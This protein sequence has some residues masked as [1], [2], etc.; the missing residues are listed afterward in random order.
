MKR[1]FATITAGAVV[2]LLALVPVTAIPAVA[3]DPLPAIVPGSVT[4]TERDS[5]VGVA[6]VSI[7]LDRPSTET[8]TAEWSTLPL[9]ATSPADFLSGSGTL[10]FVPGDTSESVS[11]RI[12]GDL[13]D[14]D[15]EL[16]AVQVTNPTNAT[17]G[18]FMG[19]G[20]V[21][22]TDNDPPPVVT[23]G[24]VTVVE[25]DS[26]T[27]SAAVPVTLD[28]PS[29]KQITV[30]YVT[31]DST[32][33]APGDY[34]AASGSVTFAPGQTSRTV[35]VSVKGDTAQEADEL[36]LVS[37]RN[38]TNATIGGFY[39]LGLVHIT[40]DDEQPPVITPG[41]VAVV[42]GDSGTVMAAVPITLDRPSSKQIT[43]EY[44]TLDNS[45]VA[46]G[47]YA[48]ASGTVTFAP[49]ETSQTVDITINGDTAQEADELAL[50]SFRNP[51]SGVMGG[52]GGIGIVFISDDDPTPIITPGLVTVAEGNSG[53][54]IAAVPVTL[55]RPRATTITVD[56]ATLDNT[57]FSPSDF[58]PASGTVTFAPGQT[59]QT[60]NITVNGD[61]QREADELALVSFSNPSFGTLGGFYG[62][63]FVNI[64]NDDTQVPALGFEIDVAS[65]PPGTVVNGQVDPADVAEVCVTDVETVQD[66]FKE[67]ALVV[68]AEVLDRYPNGIESVFPPGSPPPLPTR[69]L[70][71]FW[72]WT[73][74][75]LIGGGVVEDAAAAE[76]V[77]P[78]LFV[79]AFADLA[80]Q[81]P[82]GATGNFD[83]ETGQGSA[84]VPDVDP[85]ILALVA[86]CVM[87]S[88]D[89]S[90]IQQG[91]EAT[92][93][94][95]MEEFD[96]PEMM[97][98]E[99][100]QQVLA[101]LDEQLF[102]PCE[103]CSAQEALAAA[104]LQWGP[105]LLARILH[106]DALGVQVFTVLPD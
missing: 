61:L 94:F 85:G 20:F 57:A 7:V 47:D 50:V 11:V 37:F 5:G 43:V 56:Y 1:R 29:S 15:Q 31:L 8:V 45:A 87:P 39:G 63:G 4:V 80:T 21:F 76:A 58:A 22:V 41:S 75:S 65:G 23:P 18:G 6:T 70:V 16:L 60:V 9:S 74:Y 51:S 97:T 42:E 49:G 83:P 98:M 84:V 38:P 19:L 93:D 2:M 73:F 104:A 27:V 59:S 105:T 102:P 82:V 35:N 103:G 106:F 44:V 34:T 92:T 68:V 28:R 66:R 26:G 88:P 99:N 101:T 62:M 55:D 3:E 48:P 89:L 54:A 13:E 91:V 14:E 53:T 64:T 78:Q 69:Q 77:L 30:E 52:F 10:T 17:V 79:M 86:A 96:L 36:A 12:N 81:Q 46:P 40:N 33:V 24:A 72:A 90:V 25:G 67:Y 32:A 100:I 95:W 71:E